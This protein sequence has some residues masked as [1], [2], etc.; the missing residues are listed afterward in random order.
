MYP[1]PNWSGVRLKLERPP[2]WLFY[3]I[4]R[5]GAN[6]RS[7]NRIPKRERNLINFTQYY[8]EKCDVLCCCECGV[9]DTL[10]FQIGDALNVVVIERILARKR[11]IEPGFEVSRPVSICGR[12][13]NHFCKLEPLG[14]ERLFRNCWTRMLL[15]GKRSRKVVTFNRSDKFGHVQPLIIVLH[16]PQTTYNGISSGRTVA[17]RCENGWR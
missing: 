5:E 1:R 9:K 3:R 4:Q 10:L 14:S 15:H 8:N 17:S 12:H 16:R 11:T 7:N 13:P 2:K 6:R